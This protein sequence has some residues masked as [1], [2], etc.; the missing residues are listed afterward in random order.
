MKI[1]SGLKFIDKRSGR[2]G[3]IG[4][5]FECRDRWDEANDPEWYVYFEGFVLK[6][7][8]ESQIRANLQFGLV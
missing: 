2:P 6:I 3:R 1:K 7:L 5:I 4:D 8:P